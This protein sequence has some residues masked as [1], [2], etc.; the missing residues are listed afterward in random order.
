MDGGC[1]ARPRL[2]RGSETRG[3]SVHNSNSD[4]DDN[5]RGQRT[6]I[7][8]SRP[9]SGRQSNPSS[10]TRFVPKSNVFFNL[11]LSMQLRSCLLN[12]G[13]ERAFGRAKSSVI[14]GVWTGL[15]TRAMKPHPY[16][17]AEGQRAICR[18][19]ATIKQKYLLRC[20]TNI[21]LQYPRSMLLL[22]HGLCSN[23]NFT[24]TQREV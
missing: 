8:P 16:A 24:K 7:R 15:D 13:S 17:E 18:F 19:C 5:D 1:Y 4:N 21:R 23:T 22:H 20:G 11:L 6:T 3:R 10:W 2:A 12:P 14:P 9:T